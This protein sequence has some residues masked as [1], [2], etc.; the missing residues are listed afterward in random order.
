VLVFISKIHRS[1]CY[2]IC[3]HPPKIRILSSFS[4]SAAVCPPLGNGG[5]PLVSINYQSKVS[6]SYEYISLN[7][8]LLY[9]LPPC[10]PN[11]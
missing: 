5:F 10:P 7:E 9:P 11:I 8:V 4:R 3:D 6:T 1:E 2:V